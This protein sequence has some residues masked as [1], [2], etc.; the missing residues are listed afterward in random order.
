MNIPWIDICFLFCWV[1]IRE[2]ITGSHNRCMFNL[3]KKSL[4]C[5]PK[6]LYINFIFTISVR[7]GSSTSL[8]TL[9]I[10]FLIVAILAAVKWYL[11]VPLLCIS[12]MLSEAEHLFTCSLANPMPS[13]V[14]WLF[15]FFAYFIGLFVFL[16]LSCKNSLHI[17]NTNPLSSI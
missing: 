4:H 14:K 9:A 8:S 13:L 7:F 6:W 15:K 1:N 3:L 17:L 12:L 16:L 10:I 11:I 2:E 5:F